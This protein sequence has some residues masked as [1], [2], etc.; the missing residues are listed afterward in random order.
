[1]LFPTKVGRY[2]REEFEAAFGQFQESSKLQRY[3]YFK[4]APITL[5]NIL[6]EDILSTAHVNS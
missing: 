1:M 3:T 6:R 2:T 4:T 5:D